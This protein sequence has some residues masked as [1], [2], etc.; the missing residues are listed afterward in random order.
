MSP[1]DP[2]PVVIRILLDLCRRE[3]GWSLLPEWPLMLLCERV[4]SSAGPHL[5]TP[6]EGFRRV[7]EAISSGLLLPG[8][9][10]LLDPCEKDPTDALSC[11]THQERD[12]ITH[13][14]Q[15]RGRVASC[16]TRF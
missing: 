4:I 1:L 6:S 15:V 16:P 11:L 10:G 3:A 9:P 5:L 13:A 2:A 12:C 7:L 14:A 8:S